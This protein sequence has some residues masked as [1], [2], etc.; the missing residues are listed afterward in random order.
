MKKPALTALV[1]FFLQPYLFAQETADAFLQ[2]VSE[3]YA[4]ILDYQAEVVIAK[5]GRSE[6]GT[7]KYKAPDSLRIDYSS[8][9][10]QKLV[11]NSNM[12]ELYI[13]RYRMIM[14]QRLRGGRSSEAAGAVLGAGGI[15]LKILRD[16]YSVS[17]VS[18][19]S[20]MPLQSG[21]NE[22][23]VKLNFKWRVNTE[24]FRTLEVAVNPQTLLIRQ[25][26]GSTSLFETVR[27]DF[28]NVRTNI[29]IPNSDFVLELEN[30][31]G[32]NTYSDFLFP[33]EEK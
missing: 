9:A 32:V 6:R 10:D 20:P 17:Y 15:G 11:V 18:G 24:G 5:G 33:I 31:S 25:I 3:A 8:P 28:V 22:M 12:L 2:R 29:G 1:A 16:N 14:Q 21:S 7:L 19:P 23:V 4:K 26:V 13:P 27:F 30:T